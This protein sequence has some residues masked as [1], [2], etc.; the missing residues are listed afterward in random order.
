MSEDDAY[1]AAGVEAAQAAAAKP[2]SS[3]RPPARPVM[4]FPWLFNSEEDGVAV[5]ASSEGPSGHSTPP[6]AASTSDKDEEV[7]QRAVLDLIL[8]QF[9]FHLVI[10][11]VC[12][13]DPLVTTGAPAADP[14]VD[15]VTPPA[16]LPPSR[17]VQHF[18]DSLSPFELACKAHE[19]FSE[20]LPRR[21]TDARSLPPVDFFLSSKAGSR[22]SMLMT[23]FISHLCDSDR[24]NTSAYYSRWDPWRIPARWYGQEP[25]APP[26]P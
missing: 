20:E 3:K 22:L 24:E 26:S 9:L 18:T 19:F 11:A 14:D 7:H 5:T 17:Q 12:E 16:G 6:A 8:R 21:P 4:P 15:L 2:E 25:S 23:I 13:G 1:A 10:A